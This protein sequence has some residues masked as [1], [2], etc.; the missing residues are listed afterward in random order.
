LVS[1]R[2]R[3]LVSVGIVLVLAARPAAA[4]EPK[5]ATVLER[6]AA[7]VT[8]LQ[9]QLSGIVAEERYTQEVTSFA[10]RGG[11]PSASTYQSTLNCRGQLVAPIREELRSDLLLVKPMGAHEW[12]QFRDVFEADGKPVRD[13]SDRLTR[14]FLNESPSARI[15]VGRILE[16]SARFNIGEVTRNVNVPVFALQFLL[17]ANQGR[18]RFSRT[19]D[20]VPDTFARH[21]MPTGAFRTSTEVWIVE[22]RETQTGTVIRTATRQDLPSRGRFW[23]EPTTGR[24]L[25]SELIARDRTVTATIDVSYQSEPLLGFLVPIEMRERYKSRNGERI[26]ADATYGQFR[27]FQVN[28]DETFAPIIRK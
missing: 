16:E 17:P 13:R 2:L 7:Y 20:R 9:R 21:D 28:V 10:N 24:V 3:D 1:R 12:V 26:K 15:Q 25:M 27:Q 23:I 19:R 14:L 6:A 22:Y 11:C 8:E 18:F 4:Q 5:L